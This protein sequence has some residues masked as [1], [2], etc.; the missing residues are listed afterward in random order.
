MPGYYCFNQGKCSHL[1]RE[2]HEPER[3]E[4]VGPPPVS[5]P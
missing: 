1:D 3:A 2:A 5:S 4:N